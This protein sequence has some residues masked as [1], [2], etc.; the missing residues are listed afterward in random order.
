MTTTLVTTVRCRDLLDSDQDD[1]RCRRA[2]DTSRLKGKWANTGCVISREE[3]KHRIRVTFQRTK[4]LSN[5]QN[6]SKQNDNSIGYS[7][8]YIEYNNTVLGQD[9]NMY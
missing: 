1:F 3:I 9:K 2:V 6:K 8:R 4:F 7:A 5:G